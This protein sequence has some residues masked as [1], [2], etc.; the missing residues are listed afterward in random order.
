MFTHIDLFAGGAGGFALGMSQA[1]FRTVAAVERDANGVATYR[2]NNPGT[3]LIHADI[4][5]VRGWDLVRLLP[6]DGHC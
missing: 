3:P 2:A 5:V 6:R 4:R 1:G